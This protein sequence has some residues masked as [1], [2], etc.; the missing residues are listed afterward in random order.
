M[1]RTSAISTFTLT[2]LASGLTKRKKAI[3]PTK[4]YS[5][6]IESVCRSIGFLQ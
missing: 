4:P 5:Q 1:G 6:T 3:A 2:V